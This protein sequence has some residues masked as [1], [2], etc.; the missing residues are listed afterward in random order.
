MMIKNQI[1]S[2]L[3]HGEHFNFLLAWYS[4]LSGHNE[5]KLN[6]KQQQKHTLL[7]EHREVMKGCVILSDASICYCQDAGK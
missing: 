3:T 2:L 4:T 5:N 7:C 6:N 1:E